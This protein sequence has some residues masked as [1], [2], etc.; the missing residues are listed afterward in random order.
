MSTMDRTDY[1]I[2]LTGGPGVGKT[3][4]LAEFQKQG[5]TIVQEDARRIIREQMETG[6]DALP[7]KNKLHYAQLMLDA[8]CISYK[9]QIIKSPR[10]YIFF[11][12]GIPD[13]L[14]YIAMENLIFE[15]ELL[16]EAKQLRYHRKVF[17][18][19]PW[20][21]IYENDDERKQTWQEAEDTFKVMKNT[22]EKLG[23][24]TIT[25]PQASIEKRARFI[26]ETL[27]PKD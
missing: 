4:L 11:D 24:E 20:A 21:D 17:I 12:R 9:N 16:Q 15:T 18:L 27:D 5:F 3:A 8:S 1:L 23:Y 2:V 6:G 13:T 7:W 19:P 26:L 25:V 14:T 22:Y 10:Q